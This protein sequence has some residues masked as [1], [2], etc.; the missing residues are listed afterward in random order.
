MS[1]PEKVLVPEKPVPAGDVPNNTVRVAREHGVHPFKQMAEILGLRRKPSY[2]AA[3]EYFS[4]DAFHPSFSREEKRQFVGEYGSY[5]L[6]LRLSPIAIGGMRNLANEKVL[7]ENTLRGFGLRATETQAVIGGPRRYGSLPLFT[8]IDEIVEFFIERARYPLFLK[9]IQGSG[10]VGSAR[11]E[12]IAEDGVIT[13]HNGKT[14]KVQ[15]LAAELIE[16]DRVGHMVQAA[17]IQHP[18]MTEIAG[19]ALGSVRVVTVV[20]NGVP[21]VLYALWKIPSPTAMSDNFWQSGSMIALVDAESGKIARVRLGAG[22]NAKT[23]EAHPVSEKPFTDFTLPDWDK[24][25]KLA[26]DCHA[27]TPDLGVIGW[28]VGVSEDGPLIIEANTNPHHHLYQLAAGRG[29]LNADF[30]PVFDRV[31]ERS[32]DLI[33]K[34]LAH[35]K[36]VRRNMRS[37]RKRAIWET[38]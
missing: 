38:A 9:P 28:D 23:I 29:I 18:A 12:S 37:Q 17:V 7:Y 14:C 34:K 36:V 26:I 35:N 16:D 32:K 4:S 11:V 27:I 25:R 13:L 5:Q 31:A 24:V 19:P 22:I 20:E 30:A 6:N 33:K 15:D 3:H 21:A 8:R 1:G 10:S 2:F